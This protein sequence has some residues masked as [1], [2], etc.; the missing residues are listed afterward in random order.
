MD[1]VRS[2][3][4]SGRDMVNEWSKFSSRMDTVGSRFYSG[5]G[6]IWATDGGSALVKLSSIFPI[7]KKSAL[8]L[9]SYIIQRYKNIEINT[10][11]TS[12]THLNFRGEAP[13]FF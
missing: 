13:N 5:M 3:F 10:A 7:Y 9:T 6:E 11:N 8:N 4:S 2:S 1:T 12:C